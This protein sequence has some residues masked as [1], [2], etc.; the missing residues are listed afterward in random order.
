MHSSGASL[1]EGLEAFRGSSWQYELQQLKLANQRLHEELHS[2]EG[3]CAKSGT[4]FS[5]SMTGHIAV[6]PLGQPC[7][8]L[9]TATISMPRPQ[10]PQTQHR[11][12][13][14]MPVHSALSASLSGF[15]HATACT[16]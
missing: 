5:S 3:A 2:L 14:R 12:P 9:S 8:S 1:F 4:G 16:S 10:L 15:V 11:F 13:S 7:S 6:V